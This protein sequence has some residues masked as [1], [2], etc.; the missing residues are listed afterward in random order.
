MSLNFSTNTI[1]LETQFRSKLILTVKSV[2]NTNSVPF[3]CILHKTLVEGPVRQL[4]Y[5][6]Y[7]GKIRPDSLHLVFL[8][9]PQNLWYAEMRMWEPEVCL[10]L[11]LL[12]PEQR[13]L[14]FLKESTFMAHRS[15]QPSVTDYFSAVCSSN[16]DE[17]RGKIRTATLHTL[18]H[19]RNQGGKY[20]KEKFEM[21]SCRL[22][23]HWKRQ[24]IGR[25][26]P[27]TSFYLTFVTYEKKSQASYSCSPC[28]SRLN[29]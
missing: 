14:S 10:H 15:A 3:S 9:G 24:S 21:K 6:S 7:V 29:Q 8:L 27:L 22:S 13:I 4:L 1:L 11:I 23:S 16:R 19:K 18:H 17:K 26:K 20:N 2:Q 25:D 12:D 5:P 28:S